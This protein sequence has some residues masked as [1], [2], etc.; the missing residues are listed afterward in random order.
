MTTDK[1]IP[2]G[3]KEWTRF[4]NAYVSETGLNIIFITP[5][6][7]NI[8]EFRLL[9]EFPDQDQNLRGFDT[10]EKRMFKTFEEG[11]KHARTVMLKINAENRIR[12]KH[13]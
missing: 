3:W 5:K 2:T 1:S 13:S 11:W 6:D 7:K 4:K 10:L 12:N 9:G 8:F